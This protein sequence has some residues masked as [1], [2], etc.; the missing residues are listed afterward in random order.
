[1]MTERSSG[2]RKSI[3]PQST[4]L[5]I[6]EAASLLGV[7]TRS[8]YYYLEDGSLP[9]VRVGRATMLSKE[10]VLSFRR[11]APGRTRINTQT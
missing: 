2:E 6:A 5:T 4:Y 10:E 11:K 3:S 8:V 9:G 1:M 7:Q